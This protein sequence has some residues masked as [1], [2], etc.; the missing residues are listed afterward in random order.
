MPLSPISCPQHSAPSGHPGLVSF[1]LPA[2]SLREGSR[3][4]CLARAPPGIGSSRFPEH[5]D[6]NFQLSACLLMGGK[7]AETSLAPGPR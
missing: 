5:G 1:S 7:R 2:A 3:A 4:A 6:G